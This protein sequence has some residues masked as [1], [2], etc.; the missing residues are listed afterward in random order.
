MRKLKTKNLYKSSNFLF[1]ADAID[2]VKEFLAKNNLKRLTKK[3]N[4]GLD[5]WRDGQKLYAEF[6]GFEV[7]DKIDRDSNGDS[8][9]VQYVKRTIDLSSGVTLDRDFKNELVI[10]TH[11]RSR[12]LAIQ[13]KDS[14]GNRKTIH[15][16]GG[17]G[18]HDT[19]VYER[20]E[21]A[22]RI[23]LLSNVSY[24]RR[25][26]CEA[27]LKKALYLIDSERD[28]KSRLEDS[29]SR[30]SRVLKRLGVEITG[31]FDFNRKYDIL[32]GFVETS[33]DEH[34]ITIGSWTNNTYNSLPTLFTLIKRKSEIKR[35]KLADI[36]LEKTGYY[37]HH[38]KATVLDEHL[39]DA[40]KFGARFKRIESAKLK[41]A[42]G[43]K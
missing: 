14:K 22:E 15:L 32:V 4:E 23:V 6:E 2:A 18:S 40:K 26:R 35:T 19:C 38:N 3:L 29:E 5:T 41:K 37:D 16:A 42:G 13:L 10:Y 9:S 7:V 17:I 11:D 24:E 36:G 21:V 33:L 1:D 43:A 20:K 30:L 25:N 28:L 39:E 31:A 12:N 34:R 8:L 27:I